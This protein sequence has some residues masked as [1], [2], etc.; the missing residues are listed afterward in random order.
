[1]SELT[2]DKRAYYEWMLENLTLSPAHAGWV[3][4]QLEGWNVRGS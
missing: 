2:P 1:M 3:R 4:D